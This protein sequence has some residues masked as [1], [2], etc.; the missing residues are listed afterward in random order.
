VKRVLR[1]NGRTWVSLIDHRADSDLDPVSAWWQSFLRGGAAHIDCTGTAS[2]IRVVDAFSGCGCLTLGAHQAAIATGRRLDA[3]AAIDVDESALEVHRANFGTKRTFAANAAT[4]VDFHVSD[5]GVKSCFAYEPEILEPNLSQ[6]VGSVDLFLA[7]PPCQ[8]HSNFNNRTRREDPRNLLYLT[9]IALAVALRTRF[10]II[11]NVP[12][13]VNDKSNVVAIAKALLSSS[14]Y[15]YVD[16]HVLATHELGGAQT[17]RRHFLVAA[18]AAMK[19]GQPTIQTVA[20]ALSRSPHSVSWAIGDLLSVQG[21]GS[22]LGVMDT[23]PALSSDNRSRID[24]LFDNNLYE[25][26]N[27][28][29]PDCHRDGHT[30]PSVYGRLRWEKPAQTITT[31]FLTPG[32][33]RYIHP[34]QRR[35]IT[36]HE[37]ARLQSIPDSFR[38][39]V[40]EHD[41]ARAALT[42]WIG[43]AVPPLLGYAAALPLLA[44]T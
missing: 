9:A 25:L 4:L 31:G 36:P 29:R 5:S 1:I 22:S 34:V 28:V 23:I 17:R 35:V 16:D 14:G 2:Q 41:P 24:F 30:Y 7:G 32:R 11:E 8:G 18:L 33:G 10:L 13:V 39:V 38:F 40:N 20:H 27:A 37:A 44:S 26:P 21:N 19:R 12:E 42:K 43:D 3:V 6:E 15:Q